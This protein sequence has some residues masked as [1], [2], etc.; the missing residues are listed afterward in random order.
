MIRFGES[1]DLK[2]LAG[3]EKKFPGAYVRGKLISM[4]EEMENSSTEE[5][6]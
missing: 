3:E 2:S 4:L 5:R 1:I 6:V